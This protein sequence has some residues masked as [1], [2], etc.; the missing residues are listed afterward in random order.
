MERDK[1]NQKNPIRNEKFRSDFEAYKES[2]AR[3]FNEVSS[4]YF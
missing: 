3:P 2:P 4:G 1:R